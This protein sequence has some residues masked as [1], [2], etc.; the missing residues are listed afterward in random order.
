MFFQHIQQRNNNASLKACLIKADVKRCSQTLE[1]TSAAP[2]PSI[3]TN[4]TSSLY[5]ASM[6]QEINE[7]ASELTLNH[8]CL[9]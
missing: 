7:I 8:P 2:A 3:Q 5:D 4:I 6:R 1:L 9:S